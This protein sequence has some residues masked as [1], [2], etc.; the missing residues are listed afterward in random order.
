MGNPNNLIPFQFKKGQ[1]GNPN[2][3]PSDRDLVAVAIKSTRDGLE[4]VETLIDLMRNAKAE[5]TRLAATCELWD[6]IYG[7][8]PASDRPALFG[9][10]QGATEIRFS[11][12]FGPRRAP[13]AES[14]DG[15]VV[16]VEAV[17][18]EASRVDTEGTAESDA[19]DAE[20]P[21]T[22]E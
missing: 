22:P 17:E 21:E 18:A 19:P 1:S 4:L 20:T 12:A 14:T 13:G 5:K 2:G 16:E 8:V 3:R 9:A 10:F 15:A 7:R 6:R 11:A